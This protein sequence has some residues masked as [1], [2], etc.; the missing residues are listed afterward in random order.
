MRR[1]AHLP[2]ERP[3]RRTGQVREAGRRNAP[4]VPADVQLVCVRHLL[5]R[6][7]L[8]SGRMV[9][10]ELGHPDVQ[11]WQ[12]GRMRPTQHLSAPRPVERKS[13]R[14]RLLL[15]RK[16]PAVTRALQGVAQC[17]ATRLQGFPDGQSMSVVQPQEETAGSL[18]DMHR[19]PNA[20]AAHSVSA[21]HPQTFCVAPCEQWVPRG[22]APQSASALHS[23]EA[24]LQCGPN[25][26]LAQSAST[27]Q[28]MHV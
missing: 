6:D 19:L 4:I 14:R 25:V 15:R 27:R 8:R 20:L 3:P 1:W 17:P 21:W 24:L 11:M 16:L 9:R 5:R 23:H 12:P 22:L 10:S 26:L 7:L 13:L 28:G 2:N 18:D